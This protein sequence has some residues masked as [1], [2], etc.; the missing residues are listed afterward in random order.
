MHTKKMVKKRKKQWPCAFGLGI[1][2]VKCRIKKKYD[3]KGTNI[4]LIVTFP[5]PPVNLEYKL[6]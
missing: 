3:C 4:D 5:P 6:I 1:F 2:H